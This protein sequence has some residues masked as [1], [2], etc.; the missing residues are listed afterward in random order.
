[1]TPSFRTL[2]TSLALA[3]LGGAATISA[4]SIVLGLGATAAGAQEAR[5]ATATQPPVNDGLPMPGF[6]ITKGDTAIV[7]T[8]RQND[9]LS[10]DGVT[11]GVVGQSFTENGTVE[12]LDALFAVA[13]EVGMPLFVS[14]HY[15]YEHDH[16]WHFEGTLETL[17]HNIGMFDRPSALDMTGFEG[18]GADWLDSYKH[19]F[20]HDHVFGD[21]PTQ[22]LRP[23]Q[24]RSRAATTQERHQQG[25]PRRHVVQPLHRKPHALPDRGRL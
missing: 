7:I 2:G 21:Q 5:A 10:P 24:Q 8:D 20:E 15:Y 6:D 18:S 3:I 13:E 16:K 9:F 14:P 11:W 12:N 25:H 19:Y 17:M 1:M 23:G 4:G 22:D